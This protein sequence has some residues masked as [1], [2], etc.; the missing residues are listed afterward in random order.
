MTT[1]PICDCEWPNEPLR[2]VCGYDFET[3]NTHEAIRSL[4]IQQRSAT[5]RWLAGV[6]LIGSTM[7]T[8]LL[9]YLYPAAILALP[10]ILAGQVLFGFGLVASG[11][12]RSISVSRR[13]SR[14]KT[15]HQLPP[16][17]IVER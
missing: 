14:A 10:I 3:G 1:C 5:Y 9:G 15:T 6:A 13:L 7:V 8:I 2:C 12:G 11:L 4:T 16:A 17:R